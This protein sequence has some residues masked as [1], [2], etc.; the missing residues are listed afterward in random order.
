M[1]FVGYVDLQVHFERGIRNGNWNRLSRSERALYR[2]ALAYTRS[3]LIV[4]SMVV[5]KLQAL[6]AR[7]VE[8]RGM[9]ILKRG[10][11]R[12]RALL[13]RDNAGRGV[14]L[15]APSFRYWLEDRDYIFWL[16]LG[17]LRLRTE[18]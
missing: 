16:G 13:A 5:T 1:V 8:T 4:G 3:R 2:A 15:W 10:M 12:A 14:F 18:C 11:E 7:L 6:M 17:T 9:R